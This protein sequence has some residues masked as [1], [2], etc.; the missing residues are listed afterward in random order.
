[1]PTRA[2]RKRRC[3][4][5]FDV[6]RTLTGKQGQAFRCPGNEEQ[7]G[8][9]DGAYAGGT[10]VLSRLATGVQNTFCRDCYRS[11]VSSGFLTG[12]GSVERSRILSLLGGPA[13]TLSTSW[14]S[15]EPVTS[16]LVV[17]ALDGQK[18]DTVRS[19]VNWYRDHRSV[20]LAPDQVHF[21]D[22]RS[23]NVLPFE[24]TGFNARQVSCASRD[25]VIGMC[26]ATPD[27]IVRER[28]VHSCATYN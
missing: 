6:D 18:Q 13:A 15:R 9:T 17:G 4:C 19:I 16:A 1:M 28:G 22:D 20:S 7:A 27:E 24:G 8:T 25:T 23:D 21:F 14:S 3:L 26:G 2:G 5:V 10:L 11:I 12:E